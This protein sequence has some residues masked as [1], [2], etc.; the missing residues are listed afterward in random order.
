MSSGQVANEKLLLG[1]VN[2]LV[3]CRHSRNAQSNHVQ[4]S[5][6]MAGLGL[7]TLLQLWFILYPFIGWQG[8]WCSKVRAGYTI[9]FTSS[10]NFKLHAVQLV[11]TQ[12]TSEIDRCLTST[13]CCSFVRPIPL[14]GWLENLLWGFFITEFSLLV[15]F[16]TNFCFRIRMLKFGHEGSL[17]IWTYN[18]V[19]WCLT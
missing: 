1:V 13:V 7:K 3:T 5:N 8:M 14:I 15:S 6:K 17:L 16:L 19:W 2:S 18:N 10:S 11:H 9:L 12:P 4:L